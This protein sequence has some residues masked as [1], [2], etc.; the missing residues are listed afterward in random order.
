MTGAS[1]EG[2][3]HG[4]RALWIHQITSVSEISPTLSTMMLDVMIVRSKRSMANIASASGLGIAAAGGVGRALGQMRMHCNRSCK[5]PWQIWP[6]K[7][8]SV[9]ML[10]I[11]GICRCR[12]RRLPKAMAGERFAHLYSSCVTTRLIGSAKSIDTR[13]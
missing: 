7:S 13:P 3:G 12:Q 11:A 4:W 8:A 2:E 5:P 10:P 6:A 1:L 9:P